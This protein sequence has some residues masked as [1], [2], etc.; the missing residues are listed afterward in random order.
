MARGVTIK[1]AD[2]LM[3][4]LSSLERRGAKRAL[5]KATSAAA[6]V[7]TRAVKA[8]VP[9]DQGLLKKAQDSKTV[10]RGYLMSAIIGANVARLKTDSAADPTRP[11]NI[12]H[13]VEF[14]HVAPDG[15]V[16]PPDSYMRRAADSAMP[17]AEARY[18]SKLAEEI[19]RE[20]R[21]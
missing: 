6:T 8:S 9:V 2:R 15:S 17:A 18:V 4:T 16:V 19:E 14:G 3:K 1:G 11:T 21:K 7:L 12:D 5:R 20:M 10:Q 13:L